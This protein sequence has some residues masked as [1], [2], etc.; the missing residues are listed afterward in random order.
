MIGIYYTYESF[1]K[2]NYQ[3]YIID[4]FNKRRIHR[5]F[6]LQKSSLMRLEDNL[7]KELTP[8]YTKN[9]ETMNS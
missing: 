6:Y 4:G 5:T 1:I 9:L 2:T 8:Y 7:D 3:L